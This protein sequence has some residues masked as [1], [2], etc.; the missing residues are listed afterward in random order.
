MATVER[1]LPEGWKWVRL[2]E[3]CEFIRGVSFS[4]SEVSTVPGNELVC[5]LRAGN[6]KYELD[7]EDDL[8]WVSREKIRPEQFLRLGDIV[9]SMSSGSA[10]VVGKSAQ[11]MK[12]VT[13]S[14][15]AFCG[16]IRPKIKEQ[17]DYIALWL[18]SPFFIQWR[19]PGQSGM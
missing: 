2:G 13:A 3:V 8:I 14:V 16:I 4:G 15:G 7:F 1:K 6:I 17:A 11:V 5:I 12:A 10:N 9:I 19:D 18:R